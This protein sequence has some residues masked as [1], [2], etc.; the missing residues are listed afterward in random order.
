MLNLSQNKDPKSRNSPATAT[1]NM[2][3]STLSIFD[4]V[5]FLPQEALYPQQQWQQSSLPNLGGSQNIF[6]NKTCHRQPCLL[7]QKI[8]QKRKHHKTKHPKQSKTSQSSEA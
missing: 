3:A 8:Q 2:F 5:L 4:L 6:Q 1:I 7:H